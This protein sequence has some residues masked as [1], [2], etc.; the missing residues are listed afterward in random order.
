LPDE[1]ADGWWARRS[2]PLPTQER[3]GHSTI[4]MTLDICGH[5]F[6][7]LDDSEE[8]AAAERVLLG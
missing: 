3:M 2:A 8:P 6:P 5:L 7:R 4:V 1:I